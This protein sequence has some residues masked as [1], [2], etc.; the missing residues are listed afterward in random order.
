MFNED[1]MD[2]TL[3]G[4]FDYHNSLYKL[5]L[6][7]QSWI[8]WNEHMEDLSPNELEYD[9]YVTKITNFYIFSAKSIIF[10]L[11]KIT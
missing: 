2:F 11:I 6:L 1:W 4:R 3:G 10:I 8:I 9:I 5:H 7:L